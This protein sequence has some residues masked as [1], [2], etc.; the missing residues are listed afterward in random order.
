MKAVVITGAGT[1][2]GEASALE[3]SKN[4]YFVFLLGR[5]LEPLQKVAKLCKE[6][7]AISCDLGK[8]ESVKKAVK[9]ILDS[10]MEI[11]TLVNNAG[12]FERHSFEEGSDELWMEQFNTNLFGAVR[13][14]REF[15]SYF[16]KHGGYIVNIS[17]TLG[18]APTAETIAYSA[19]KA[20][21]VNWTQGLALAGG[22]YN[23]RCNCICPGLVE[24][25]IHKDTNLENLKHIQPLGRV[26]KS[27][28]IAKSVYF[29]GT[30][31]S[32][33]TTGAVLSVDGGINLT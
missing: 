16:K 2:I 4:G 32:S 11:Q 22:S 13:I 28:E 8:L 31:N 1:G 26:G 23:I 18:L 33:W 19:S 24:T 3:F 29:L 20:A 15:F 6:A 7:K 25:P 14:T 17:S 5:R 30:D 21:M 9:E 10:K 27:E 12:I